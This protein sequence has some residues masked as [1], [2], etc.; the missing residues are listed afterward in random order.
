M[1]EQL[2]KF[3]MV[4]PILITG[5]CRPLNLPTFEPFA[6]NPNEGFVCGDSV[7]VDVRDGQTYRTVFIGGKCWFAQNLNFGEKV[8]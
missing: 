4:L 2:G 5:A 8:N 1:R 7:W 6:S 3:L